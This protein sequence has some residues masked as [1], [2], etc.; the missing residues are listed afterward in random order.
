MGWENPNSHSAQVV[1]DGMKHNVSLEQ[2]KHES[3]VATTCNPGCG[4]KRRPGGERSR[5]WLKYY[6][7]IL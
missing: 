1:T 6:F 5:A 7:I 4:S 3:A 2:T